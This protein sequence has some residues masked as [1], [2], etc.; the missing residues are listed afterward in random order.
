MAEGEEAQNH[1]AGRPAYVAAD[2]VLDKAMAGEL[3]SNPTFTHAIAQAARAFADALEEG[4]HERRD[5]PEPAWQPEHSVMRQAPPA[6]AKRN[7]GDA[8]AGA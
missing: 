1:S 2:E 4:R 3:L 6:C 5:E 8:N 7:G